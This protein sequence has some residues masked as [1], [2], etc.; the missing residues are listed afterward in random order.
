MNIVNPKDI[1][2]FSNS[3]KN[4]KEENEK[5]IKIILELMRDLNGIN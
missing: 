2:E 3:F 4:L 1:K 5:L